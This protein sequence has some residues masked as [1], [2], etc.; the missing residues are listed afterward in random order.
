M[1]AKQLVQ[2]ESLVGIKCFCFG[3][4]VISAYVSCNISELYALNIFLLQPLLFALQ[5]SFH[6]YLTPSKVK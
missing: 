1:P 2:G 3:F 6:T 5:V 4:L